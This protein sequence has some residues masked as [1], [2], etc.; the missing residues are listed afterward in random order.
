MP[1]NE[2]QGEGAAKRKT[3]SL[4][5]EIADPESHRGGSGEI[6]LSELRG[7]A[8]RCSSPVGVA[9][10]SRRD[11]LRDALT[12]WTRYGILGQLLWKNHLDL[13]REERERLDRLGALVRRKVTARADASKT[14]GHFLW[15][16]LRNARS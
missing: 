8:E 9:R 10:N 13:S 5:Q 7:A 6:T 1:E 12:C 11:R 4:L 2:T 3:V 14:L 15:L 16:L